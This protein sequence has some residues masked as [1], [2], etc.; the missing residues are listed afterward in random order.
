[1]ASNI[2][3]QRA[4]SGVATN[5]TAITGLAGTGRTTETVKDNADNI[6]DLAGT[7]RTTE[8]VKANAAALA[9]ITQYVTQIVVLTQ[10]AYDALPATKLTDSKLYVIVGA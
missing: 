2:W 3:E 8:T 7:G 1:M 4:V 5:T 6:L 10:T 9:D